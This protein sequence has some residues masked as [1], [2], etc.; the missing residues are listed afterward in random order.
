M[1]GWRFVNKS[2]LGFTIMLLASSFVF[3]ACLASDGT[4]YTMQPVGAPS[5]ASPT[6]ISTTEANKEFILRYFEALNKDKSP[7]TVD[8]YIAEQPLKDH[9]VMVESA[10]PGYQLTAEEMLAEGDMVFVNATVT[11]THKGELMGIAPTGKT[12]TYSVALT[13]RI[14]DGKIV[15][16]WM[17]SDLFGLLQQLGATVSPPE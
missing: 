15:D 10:F 16:H 13:Y 5:V 6:E 3:G 14:E 11:A 17:L 7:A 8:M 4:V 12:V 9:I 2:F 1:F